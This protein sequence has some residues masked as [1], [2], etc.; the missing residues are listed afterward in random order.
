MRREKI[1]V[2]FNK[3]K[4]E[5]KADWLIKGTSLNRSEIGRAALELGMKELEY[6][7]N[8]RGLERMKD[9]VN[10]NQGY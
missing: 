7:R 2:P 10:D 4:F 8:D 6:L 9:C 1:N 3:G 5:R